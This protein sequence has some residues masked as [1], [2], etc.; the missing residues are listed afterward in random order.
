MVG[1]HDI[2]SANPIVFKEKTL[3]ANLRNVS[4]IKV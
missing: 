4:L 2:L 1:L 3:W